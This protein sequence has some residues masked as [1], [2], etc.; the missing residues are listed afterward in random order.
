[1]DFALTNARAQSSASFS[2]FFVSAAAPSASRAAASRLVGKSL[3]LF[4]FGAL[5]WALILWAC[6]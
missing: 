3:L 4:S 1:M 5:P 6:R 2:D